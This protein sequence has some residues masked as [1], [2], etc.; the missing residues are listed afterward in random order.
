MI[1]IYYY[2][3]LYKF[4]NYNNIRSNKNVI[5]IF[6]KEWKILNYLK[7]KEVY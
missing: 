5:I 1:N 4:D 3:V 7:I 6:I 2:I